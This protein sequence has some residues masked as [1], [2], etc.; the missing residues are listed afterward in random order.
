MITFAEHGRQ[1]LAKFI[2]D[3]II[4]ILK[5]KPFALDLEAEYL[6]KETENIERFRFDD[7]HEFT[8]QIPAWVFRVLTK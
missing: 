4:E 8:V 3:A 5:R 7:D 2:K 6:N 1:A